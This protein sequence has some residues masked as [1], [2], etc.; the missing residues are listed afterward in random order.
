ME[1][2]KKLTDF[3][4]QLTQ[5]IQETVEKFGKNFTRIEIG[6]K[7]ELFVSGRIS[8]TDLEVWIYKTGAEFTNLK[9]VDCR[10]EACDY[11][12]PDDLIKNYIRDLAGYLD[13][14]GGVG[15]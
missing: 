6:G 3:Q 8:E 7:K 11:D 9:E 10:Y 14:E 13:R 1:K 15:V 5:R 12:S 4:N 2:Y